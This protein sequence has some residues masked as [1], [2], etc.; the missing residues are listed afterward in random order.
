MLDFILLSAAGVVI[1]RVFGL[2]ALAATALAFGLGYCSRYYWTGGAFL[3]QDWI[4]A[5]VICAAALRVECYAL[6]GAFLAYAACCRVFPVLFVLPLAAF[7]LAPGH[8][9]RYGQAA[10][11]FSL[12]FAALAALLAIAG[13]LTG[14]GPGAWVESAH[15][16]LLQTSAMGPNAIGL[17]VPFSASLTNL[18]G[19]LVDAT[20]LYE[21]S[22]VAAD[23]AK[24]AHEHVVWIVLAT[25]LVC[26]ASLRLAWATDDPVVALCAGVGIVFALTTPACYYA[27]YFVLLA[28]VR[29]LA[30]A[31]TF[32]IASAAMF[33][34]AGAVFFLALHGYIRLNGAAAYVPISVLLAGVLLGW[35]MEVRPA[36]GFEMVQTDPQPS[37]HSSLQRTA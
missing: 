13:C 14:R 15:R 2:E 26:G 25:I 12:G 35:M 34:V 4:A 19:E 11:N 7:A 22:R 1:C 31:R 21:Y 27:S 3:R 17:R 8:R 28:L 37:P 10:I 23:F 9:K 24:T 20:T 36:R 18:R 5:I 6:A 32:L 33:A 30:V 29:P 16:L